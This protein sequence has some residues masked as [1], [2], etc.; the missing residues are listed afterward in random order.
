MGG[1]TLWSFRHALTNAWGDAA[2]FLLLAGAAGCIGAVFSMIFR[3]DNSFPT[4]EAQDAP[5]FGGGFK[6][7]RRF[8]FGDSHGRR[9]PGWTATADT[10]RSRENADRD[11]G[12]RH[13]QRC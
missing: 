10:W 11:A 6:G 5:R 1:F 2:F 7:S 3:M 4:S 13:V 8:H 9:Y 12:R